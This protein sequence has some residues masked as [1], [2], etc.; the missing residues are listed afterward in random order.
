MVERGPV[1]AL[2]FV[3]QLGER[4]RCDAGLTFED[5]G[6][7]RRRR[8]AEHQSAVVVRSSTAVRSVVV[9]PA[10]A[11]PTAS[12]SR[13]WPATAAAT[14][15]W[16]TSRSSTSTVSEG[17]GLGGLRVECPRDDEFFLGEDALGRDVA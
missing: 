6:G 15:A 17:G 12:T 3:E 8:D 11:G 4:V 14:S 10:P 7:L 1:G 16:M 5:M 2:P 9:L 13:S